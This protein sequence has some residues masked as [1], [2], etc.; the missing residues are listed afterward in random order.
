MRNDLDGFARYLGMAV[1]SECVTI[2]AAAD[3]LAEWADDDDDD[4]ALSTAA[5]R[6][7]AGS[8]AQRLLNVAA[9]VHRSA[10]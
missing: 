4:E 6:S 3:A 7:L 5:T 9:A 2:A 1:E 8:S 10:A